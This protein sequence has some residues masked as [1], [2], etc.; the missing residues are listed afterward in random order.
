MGAVGEP[1]NPAPAAMTEITA[2]CR[3]ALQSYYLPQVVGCV[4]FFQFQHLRCREPPQYRMPVPFPL[5]RRFE[6]AQHLLPH[7]LPA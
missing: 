3:T 5:P 1:D 2:L 4:C 7:R 6:I